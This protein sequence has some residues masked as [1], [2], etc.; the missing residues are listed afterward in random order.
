MNDN[1]LLSALTVGEFKELMRQ[2][3]AKDSGVHAEDINKQGY[4]NAKA[5][6]KAEP[7]PHVWPEVKWFAHATHCPC[8]TCRPRL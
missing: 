5:E 3:L 8:G 4:L 2:M 1:Q 7:V 6:F